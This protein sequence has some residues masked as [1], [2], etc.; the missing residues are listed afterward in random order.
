MYQDFILEDLQEHVNNRLEKLGAIIESRQQM[1]AWLTAFLTL[2]AIGSVSFTWF[3]MQKLLGKNAFMG[4]P[5]RSNNV[6]HDA[7]D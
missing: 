7:F 1:E 4:G 5:S 3:R 6:A 2:L